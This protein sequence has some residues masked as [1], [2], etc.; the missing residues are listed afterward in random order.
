MTMIRKSPVRGV[1]E[2]RQQ[3]GDE[4]GPGAA[5]APGEDG[6]PVGDG[7]VGNPPGEDKASVVSIRELAAYASTLFGLACLIKVYAVSRYSTTTTTA[8]ISTAPEQVVFGTLA[9][10]VY[11][12]MAILAYGTAW[13]AV[14]WRRSIA[15]EVWPALLAVIVLTALMTPL[16]Y[17]LISLTVLA[18]SLLIEFVIRRLPSPRGPGLLVEVRRAVRGHSFAFLG[19]ITLLV[20]FLVTLESPWASA[21]VFVVK[22]PVVSATHDPGSRSDS[23]VRLASSARPFVGHMIEE[24]LTGYKILHAETRYIM[25]LEKSQ[26]AGRYTCHATGEQLRGR[27]PLLDRLLGRPYLSPNSDCHLLVAALEKDGGHAVE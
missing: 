5:R 25:L 2:P 3:P 21:E 1:P 6:P 20:G 22:E 24:T 16:E 10:Y 17:H 14:T 8:L 4:G 13:S 26:I 11:P 12:T 23:Q 7:P 27:Q 15:R 9:V 18:V 19:G